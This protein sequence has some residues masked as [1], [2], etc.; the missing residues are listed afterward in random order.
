MGAGRVRKAVRG[1]SALAICCIALLAI[2]G[3][4][5]AAWSET[6]SL[7][8]KQLHTGE[9]VTI[10]FKRNGRYDSEGLKQINYILR[11]W[12]RNE[13]TTMDPALLDLVWE[14]RNAVGSKAPVYVLSGYRSPVTNAMLRSRSR[15]VAKTSQHMVG[16][17][18][19][20]YLPDVPLSKLRETA[21]KFQRGGVGYY[22][23]SGSPFV[24]M[25]T[26]SVRHWPRMT[27][28]QLAK[29]FPDGKTLHIPSDGKP[30]PGYQLA[31]AEIKR[32][33][34]TRFASSGST[35]QQFV[36]SNSRLDPS[37]PVMTASVSRSSGSSGSSSGGS[38]SGSGRNL[39][40]ALFNSGEDGD[41]EDA[42]NSGGA[43]KTEAPAPAVDEKPAE[44]QPTVV[45]SLSPA[46]PTPIPRLKP[47][48]ATL[49]AAPEAMTAAVTDAPVPMP[50]PTLV[51]ALA[52]VE[53]PTLETPTLEAPIL[54]EK[55]LITASVMAPASLPT[56][57]AATLPRARPLMSGTDAIGMLIAGNENAA[58]APT[59][60]QPVQQ[61]QSMTA[62]ALASTES[63]G[64][65][66]P[67]AATFTG[68]Q[69][70]LR[71]GPV[72]V[73]IDYRHEALRPYMD[74]ENCLRGQTFVA[75]RHPD[76]TDVGALTGISGPVVVNEFTDGPQLIYP[77]RRFTGPAVTPV[78]TRTYQVASLDDGLT[79]GSLRRAPVEPAREL[80]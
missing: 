8:F 17:A 3:T 23:T 20:F 5:R 34:T 62:T 66:A 42:T 50:K 54:E 73:A 16:K 46:A 41:E 69:I 67:F 77:M 14:V 78:A 75:L 74:S 57:T 28:S 39:I 65:M 10:T 22:P 15:G 7:S 79:T 6:R 72:L 24:H 55:P 49:V 32:G 61:S 11:D 30:M 71:D 27:R 80:R 38:S 35:R 29:V 52:P 48:G 60:S 63:V 19:D 56:R 33:T 47:A 9:T 40:A 25:D 70:A 64:E 26:G 76:Q 18:L 68:Q 53:A 36:S 58:P 13:S 45:A 37:A 12:R 44:E 1:L 4:T 2:D 59:G 43:A 31:E 51:A 21:L